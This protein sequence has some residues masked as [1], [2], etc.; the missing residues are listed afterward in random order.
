MLQVLARSGTGQTL[1]VYTT[2]S[3]ARDGPGE[4]DGPEEFHVV[5]VDNGRSR[6]LGS[7]LA[8]ILY[9]IRC[10]A[11][12]NAC[13][14]Y[15]QIGGHAYGSVYSGPGRRGAHA[16]A[17]RHPRVPRPAAREHAVRR[18]PR[19]LPGADRPPAHAAAAAGGGRRGR[20][21]AA[22]GRARH[23]GL[24]VDRARVRPRSAGRAAR[25]RRWRRSARRTAGCGICPGT[26]PAWTKTRDF[27]APAHQSFTETWKARKTPPPE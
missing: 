13:P 16:G 4:A 12:L 6:V 9:C 25:P 3:P 2:S 26:S 21:V 7:E 23:A 8:E 27:P 11:C 1:T 18:V 22:V 14:V 5:L 20:R 17:R 24:R 10:G 19:R 15:Q